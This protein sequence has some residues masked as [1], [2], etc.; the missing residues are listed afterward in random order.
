M[1]AHA[2]AIRLLP[3][4]DGIAMARINMAADLVVLW[5]D[6]D[7]PASHYQM[8]YKATDAL[9]MK[10]PIIANDISDF[11]DLARQGYLRIVPFGDWDGI[12]TAIRELFGDAGG[13]DALRAAARRLYQRQFSY[14]AA[15]GSF[16][17]AAHRALK[18]GPGVLPVA[19]RFAE[20]FAEFYRLRAA[21]TRD[22]DDIAHAPPAMTEANH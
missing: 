11:G 17:V 20:R 15:R 13:S 18:A 9:A 22:S 19:R 4:Q 1:E 7:V 14:A 16:D 5:L 12:I 10:T 2:D 21:G 8:P 3:P 6:P